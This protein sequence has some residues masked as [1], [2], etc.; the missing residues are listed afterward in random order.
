MLKSD[1]TSVLRTEL[2]GESQF[3]RVKGGHLR[4]EAVPK[5]LSC[6]Q[7]GTLSLKNGVNF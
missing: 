7:F 4:I 6:L 3:P 5:F 2:K 1:A